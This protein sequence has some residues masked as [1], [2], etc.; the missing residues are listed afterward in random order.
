MRS[1]AICLFAVIAMP[2]KVIF[3]QQQYCEINIIKKK[4]IVCTLENREEQESDLVC[5]GGQDARFCFLC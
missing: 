4:K 2:L 1:Y 5:K 3:P